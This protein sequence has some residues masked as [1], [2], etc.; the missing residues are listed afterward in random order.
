MSFLTGNKEKWKNYTDALL[1]LNIFM[2]Q[3]PTTFSM[4]SKTVTPVTVF[5]V[6]KTWLDL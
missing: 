4:V 3:N 2:M 1:N 6:N 5:D